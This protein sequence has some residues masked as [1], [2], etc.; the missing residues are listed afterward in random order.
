MDVPVLW[1]TCGQVQNRGQDMQVP[2]MR[3]GWRIP[4]RSK[5]PSSETRVCAVFAVWET[6]ESAELEETM[7][8][9]HCKETAERNDNL[10]LNLVFQPALASREMYFLFKY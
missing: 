10:S 6:T 4:T 9:P 2:A 5:V 1:M 3:A 8:G 7:E